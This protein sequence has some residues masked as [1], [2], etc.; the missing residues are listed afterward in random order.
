MFSLANVTAN[1]SASSYV[2]PSNADSSSSK[3]N[4]LLDL[5]FTAFS[6]KTIQ[7]ANF[8]L[9]EFDSVEEGNVDFD[10]K[11]ESV[12]KVA[13][14]KRAIEDNPDSIGYNISTSSL[15]NETE[16]SVDPSPL[17]SIPRAPVGRFSSEY[18]LNTPFANIQ[19]AP[20]LV[21]ALTTLAQHGECSVPTPINVE[22][23]LV[24]IALEGNYGLH[25]IL[26]SAATPLLVVKP[27]GTSNQVHGLKHKGGIYLTQS[28]IVQ[29][30]TPTSGTSCIKIKTPEEITAIMEAE[31]IIQEAQYALVFNVDFRDRINPPQDGRP[32]S[33]FI[34][35]NEYKK[36]IV[37]RDH[38]TTL[39]LE[40]KEEK[41]T[42]DDKI[43]MLKYWLGGITTVLSALTGVAA[44][45]FLYKYLKDKLIRQEDDI[46]DISDADNSYADN[47]ELPSEELAVLTQLVAENLPTVE[48]ED[49]L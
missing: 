1:L 47:S 3:T 24:I 36:F 43:V 29:I 10:K 45:V 7:R 14:N 46:S 41:T 40:Q 48:L 33:Y 35:E 30:D 49:S 5:N 12:F 16:N 39:A 11:M 22:G 28:K 32:A 38:P 27:N 19:N 17:N 42:V 9:K 6:N 31:K 37:S 25:P 15:Y 44:G 4:P 2:P 20:T 21:N 34:T 13:R 18:I 23:P 26:N 8:F